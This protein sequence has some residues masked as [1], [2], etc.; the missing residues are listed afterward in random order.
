MHST[1]THEKDVSRH[2]LRGFLPRR[3]RWVT[4]KLKHIQ[5]VIIAKLLVISNVYKLV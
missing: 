5:Q 3:E 1:S 2:R 4:N